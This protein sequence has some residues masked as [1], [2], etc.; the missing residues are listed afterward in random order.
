MITTINTAENIFEM[1]FRILKSSN[2]SIPT[3]KKKG[4]SVSESIMVMAKGKY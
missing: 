4:L 1:R 3:K 2:F